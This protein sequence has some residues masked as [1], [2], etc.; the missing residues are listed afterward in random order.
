MLLINCPFCGERAEIEFRYA[1]EAHVIRP[2][3]PD[4]ADDEEWARYLYERS[5]P[6]GD[7]AERWHH[8]H[9]CQRYFNALRNTV[10]DNFS[11]S[12]AAGQPRP[13]PEG[14]R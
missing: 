12:Y 1:G 11:T 5:N 6:A 3:E 9:G 14:E 2:G 4:K 10:S 8:V 13:D 7:L